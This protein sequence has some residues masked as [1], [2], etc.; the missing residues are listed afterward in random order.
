MVQPALEPVLVW[1]H[2]RLG[3]HVG[4][5]PKLVRVV[6]DDEPDLPL[7][8][9]DQLVDGRT[10]RLAVGSLVVDELDQGDGGI[11][12]A[13]D[14]GIADRHRRSRIRRVPGGG[15]DEQED[16]ETPSCGDHHGGERFP[17][18][19]LLQGHRSFGGIRPPIDSPGVDRFD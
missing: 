15:R 7:V 11:P 16:R 6:L 8:F 10:D 19:I 14:G 1:L 12:W 9:L 17:H 4:E 18:G 3:G 5:V 13:E 2:A